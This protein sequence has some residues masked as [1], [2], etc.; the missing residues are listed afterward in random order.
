MKN[1]SH[2]L[3]PK[4]PLNS[5]TENQLSNS[6][7]FLMEFTQKQHIVNLDISKEE[8]FLIYYKILK[9]KEFCN[10]KREVLSKCF[11]YIFLR[12]FK[13]KPIM[14]FDL[15]P[16]YEMF[17]SHFSKIFFRIYEVIRQE[18]DPFEC[19]LMDFFLRYSKALKLYA[20]DNVILEKK[21]KEIE[22][23]SIS[24]NNFRA[25]LSVLFFR[26]VSNFQ[27][28]WINYFKVSKKAFRKY[29]KLLDSL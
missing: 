1:G 23:S 3:D 8:Y 11:I 6:Y 13:G 2:Y 7:H 19:T 17:P 14:I 20:I 4:T 21:V 29:S 27:N 16:Q 24:L 22:M 28:H 18:K 12:R 25:I 10:M 9:I 5:N 15:F 26:Y